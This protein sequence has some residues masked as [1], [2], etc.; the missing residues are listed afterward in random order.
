MVLM[1]V[2]MERFQGRQNT[3]QRIESVSYKF[4]LF[5]VVF[6]YQT[7]LTFRAVVRGEAFPFLEVAEQLHRAAGFPYGVLAVFRRPHELL[8]RPEGL[9]AEGHR[10]VDDVLAIAA[11]DYES[12][13]TKVSA[14]SWRIMLRVNAYRP[15]GL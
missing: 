14:F 13:G 11:D 6:C 7:K 2:S 12:A 8:G 15:F 3:K 5:P 9:V 10:G 4:A 1:V